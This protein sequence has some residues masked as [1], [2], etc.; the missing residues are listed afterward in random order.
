M[1]NLDN[2]LQSFLYNYAKKLE[3]IC[4]EWW[5]ETNGNKKVLFR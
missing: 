3:W 2:L 4:F 5:F 1:Y